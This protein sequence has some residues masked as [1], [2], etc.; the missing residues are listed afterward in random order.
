MQVHVLA[1][2]SKGNATLLQG[3]DANI[4]IDAGISTRRIK[5]ELA[6][7]GTGLEALDGILLTHEHRDHIAGLTTLTKRYRLPVYTRPDTWLSMTLKDTIPPECC[8]DLNNSLDLGSLKIEPFAISHDAADPVGFNFFEDACKCSVV[9]DLGFVTDS[10]KRALSLSDIMVLEANHDLDML[11]NG[12]YPWSLKRRIMSNRGH[13]S[14]MDAG[15]TLARLDRKNRTDVFL[16]HLSQE[17]N[18]PDIAKNTVS[19]IL[20]EQGCE[21]GE[22][23]R[24]YLTYPDRCASMDE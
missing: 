21:V 11:K 5:Q 3:K 6:K 15:W 12:S 18:R 20:A 4:L 8:R 7:L 1:S 13:L 14:N 17:N 16:A 9:T 2:G 19:S 22:D 24:L 23:V 10:V